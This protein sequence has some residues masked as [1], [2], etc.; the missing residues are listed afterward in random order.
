MN[1]PIEMLFTRS[2]FA[3]R[4]GW[5]GSITGS[6]KSSSPSSTWLEITSA[7]V[8]RPRRR[9][10]SHRGSGLGPEVGGNHLLPADNVAGRFGVNHPL[11]PVTAHGLRFRPGVRT[12]NANARARHGDAVGRRSILRLAK[13]RRCRL[14]GGT[15]TPAG[16][17]PG[18]HRSV[19]GW[20]DPRAVAG[21][22]SGI[23]AGLR[24]RRR[25]PDSRHGGDTASCSPAVAHIPG[26]FGRVRR[27]SV[28]RVSAAKAA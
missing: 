1:R 21:S 5:S 19:E 27:T 8:A 6:T 25:S 28:G 15:R 13:G 20:W 4:R 18:I 17:V 16:P 22:A 2:R 23:G 14:R 3:W 11:A 12:I 24:I 9:R 10:S 7:P 26:R